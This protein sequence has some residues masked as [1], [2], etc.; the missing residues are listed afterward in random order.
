VPDDGDPAPR[1]HAVGGP[2]GRG[3]PLRPPIAAA[4]AAAWLLL[5]PATATA[6]TGRKLATPDTNEEVRSLFPNLLNAAC[7]LPDMATGGQPD[8]AD[9]AAA[10]AAGYRSVVDARGP[11]EP[12]GFDARRVARSLGLEYIRLPVT[13]ATLDDRTF[14]RFRSLM[15][16]RRLRPMLFHCQSGNRTGVLL[17]PYLVL[18]R[19]FHPD[20]AVAVAR[21]A[22]MRPGPMVE[23]AL[24]YARR[25][26]RR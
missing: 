10:A 16:E 21:A 20:S 7:P 17:V 15:K 8:S 4:L 5:A 24:D 25:R 9:L 26:A 22:G 18:D 23:R 1:G 19:G 13:A 2:S 6:A 3:L 14:D 11:G 12:R